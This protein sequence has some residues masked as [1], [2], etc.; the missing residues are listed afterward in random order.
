MQVNMM[1]LR[2]TVASIAG[3]NGRLDQTV[4][5]MPGASPSGDTPGPEFAV[6]RHLRTRDPCIDGVSLPQK[7]KIHRYMH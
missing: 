1:E 2:G 4:Q 6:Y 7:L 3:G 5:L